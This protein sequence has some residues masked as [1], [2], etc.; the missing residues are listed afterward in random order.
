MEEMATFKWRSLL[1][2]TSLHR[3]Q[4]L[5]LFLHNKSTGVGYMLLYAMVLILISLVFMTV[6]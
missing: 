5:I 2:F 4:I 3:L 6:K 1:H